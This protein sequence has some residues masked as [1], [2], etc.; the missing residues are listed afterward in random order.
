MPTQIPTPL[1]PEEIKVKP[2]P[3]K[4]EEGAVVPVS[5]EITGR[6]FPIVPSGLRDGSWAYVTEPDQVSWLAGSS[7][8]VVL[9]LPYTS[10]NLDLLAT[11]LALS[12][13]ITLRNNVAATNH[14]VVVDRRQV[15][16]Y[17]IEVF[18]QRRAGLTLVL[19]GG[20]DES[21][22]RRLVL[23]A[24]PVET[25]EEVIATPET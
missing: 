19:L 22:D 12:D 3:V 2:E 20:S 10:D 21:P 9:G 17:A 7:V 8:N 11:T 14:Y 15:D 13:T 1:P 18:R 25:R 24:I 5:L 23:W 4:L 6:Y 16:G